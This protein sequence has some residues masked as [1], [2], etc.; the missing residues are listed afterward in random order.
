MF[1][2]LLLR[3]HKEDEAE[4]RHTCS[5]HNP[6]QKLCFFYFECPTAFVAM[7]TLSFH[8][9]VMGKVEVGNFYCLMGIIEFY[10][11]RNVY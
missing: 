10:F 5:G 7:A 9:L 11:Y 1:K 4:T 3:S 6:L 2:I 8:I